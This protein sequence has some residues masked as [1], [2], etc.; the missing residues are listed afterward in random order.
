MGLKTPA[1]WYK[2]SSTWQSF[3]LTPACGLYR[4]GRTA[5]KVFQTP[6]PSPVPTFCVGNLT[7]G[8]GGK[9]PT[10]IALH[11]FFCEILPA[12]ISK[13]IMFVTKGYKGACKGPLRVNA[14]TDTAENVGDEPLI[15]AMTAPTIMAKNWY[16]GATF[17][18]QQGASLIIMDDGMQNRSLRPDIRLVVIKANRGLGNKHVLPGGPLREPLDDTKKDIDGIIVVR[19]QDE[20]VYDHKD[21]ISLF[22]NIPVFTVSS[23][24]ETEGLNEKYIAFCGLARPDDFFNGLSE[25]GVNIIENHDF[26]DHHIYTQKDLQNLQTRAEKAGAALLTTVKDYVRLPENFKSDVKAVHH[27]YIFDETALLKEFTLRKLRLGA[28]EETSLL[29]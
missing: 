20:N 12:H 23:L 21:I 1:F 8:G 27:K 10:A 17:A 16:K 25:K 11:N 9:T 26:P 18:K 2:N 22:E 4:L 6:T 14:Q 13:N 29:S 15:L 24:M 5:H 19:N 7:A 3:F 28:Y